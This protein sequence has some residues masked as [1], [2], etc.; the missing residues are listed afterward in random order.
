M[1]MRASIVIMAIISFS[2]FSCKGTTTGIGEK[3]AVSGIVMSGGEPIE[4]A[5][6]VDMGGG[7]STSTGKDGRFVITD[8]S[9][10]EHE[11]L[12]TKEGYVGKTIRVTINPGEI[13]EIGGI[14][15]ER[16]GSIKGKVRDEKGRPLSGVDVMIKGIGAVEKTGEDGGYRFSDIPPGRYTIV[17]GGV[18]VVVDLKG[19]VVNA[20]DIVLPSGSGLPGLRG[21]IAFVSCRGLEM[22]L[23]VLDLGDMRRRE[24]YLGGERFFF[25]GW[26]PD[27]RRG[28]ISRFLSP[29][30]IIDM[31]T[32]GVLFEIPKGEGDYDRYPSFSPD[33]MKIAFISSRWFGLEPGERP[34][35]FFFDHFWI[36]DLSIYPTL[37][38]VSKKYKAGHGGWSGIGY[39]EWSPDSRRLALVVDEDRTGRNFEI[40]IASYDPSK[41]EWDM[42]RMTRSDGW[43]YEPKWS[44]D[45]RWIAFTSERDGDAEVYLLDPIS[46]EQKNLTRNRH[47][48]GEP[49]WSPDGKEIAFTSYRDGNLEIYVMDRDGGN[50]R[51]LTKNEGN[52]WNP[53]WSPDGGWIAFISDRTGDW[54]IFVMRA[55]GRDQRNLT[56]N[57]EYYDYNPLW[58]PR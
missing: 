12:I 35:D 53:K 40:F 46:G 22:K 58:A 2:Y 26:N 7:G 52:D 13:K 47:Y 55:D 42:E 4:G 33:G 31:E 18:E 45:G 24:V 29:I 37:Y 17:S 11:I 27:G 50:L 20:P 57:P 56:K 43:D 34:E 51:N 8:L 9:P 19:G 41:S 6:V 30:Q 36:A 3:G 1:E 16:C 39:P 10:G 25:H 32:G 15:I 14:E 5:N 54:E 44:P 21:R 23:Y 48:D 28:L 38:L 49:E